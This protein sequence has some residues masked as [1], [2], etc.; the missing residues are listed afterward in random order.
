MKNLKL[1]ILILATILL[2][3]ASCEKTKQD[4]FGI[5]NFI[6]SDC[7][8]S[9]ENEKIRLKT[10][11]SNELEIT[12]S[13]TVLACCPDGEL[14]TEVSL[15]NDTIVLNEYSTDN[16]CNCLCPYDLGYTI[17]ELDYGEYKIKMEHED[18]KYFSFTIKF[19]ENTDTT[20]IINHN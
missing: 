10:V 20:I 1:T 14:K 8:N 16:N 7:K 11:N 2:S 4:V 13:N 3:I 9:L 6:H 19:N 17:G 5:K 18:Y 15:N 12:H